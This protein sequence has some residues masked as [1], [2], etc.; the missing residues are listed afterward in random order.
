MKY[1]VS[2]VGA[3]GYTGIELIRLLKAHPYASLH[4]LT[5]ESYSGR[6]VSEVLPFFNIDKVLEKFNVKKTGEESDVIFLCL[7]HTTSTVAVEKLLKYGKKLIDLSADF[8]LKDPKQYEKYYGVK[9]KAPKLLKGS[10]YGLP[11]L[12]R[13]QIKGKGFISNPGCYPTSVILAAAP[14][15][16]AGFVKTDGL[17][18]NSIS[19]ISGVGRKMKTEYHYSESHADVRA[20]RLVNHQHTPE[21]EQELTRIAGKKVTVSFSPHLGPYNRGILTTIVFDLKKKLTTEAAVELYRKSYSG[22]SFMKI[23]PAGVLP[24]VKNVFGSNMCEVGMK[25]DARLNKLIVVSAIDNLMKGASGQAVQNMN[26]MLSLPEDT[27]L[28]GTGMMP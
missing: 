9:H 3:T 2:I 17:V 19:G 6:K 24:A 25:V 10:T 13:E 23:C 7:P 18:I 11:E 16:A 14:V 21:M 28:A 26:L 1:K 27:G 22:Q 5:S 4:L 20:Y 8:R 12:Y 15:L